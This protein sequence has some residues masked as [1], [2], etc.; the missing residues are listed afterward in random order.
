MGQERKACVP[1][2][3][4]THVIVCDRLAICHGRFV[5]LVI[6]EVKEFSTCGFL[7][8]RWLDVAVQ[9]ILRVHILQNRASQG[10]SLCSRCV[11]IGGANR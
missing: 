7:P 6:V 8:W 3:V 9:R 2:Q 4:P 1:S 10:R 5:L 11:A